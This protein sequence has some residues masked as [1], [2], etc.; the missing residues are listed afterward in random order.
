MPHNT[1]KIMIRIITNLK[2]IVLL[3]I[4]G[5][6]VAQENNTLTLVSPH[7]PPYTYKSNNKIVGLGPDLIRQ[8]LEN[9]NIQYNIVMVKDYGEAVHI[10]KSNLA[11]GMFL[12]SK[13][14]ERDAIAVF[15][16]PLLINKW[17]WFML[18]NSELNP[19][20][21]TFKLQAGIGTIKGTNTYKWLKNN[22]Y[23]IVASPSEA[24]SLV[25]ML[26]S[27]RIDAVFLSDVVFENELDEK[28]LL[29]LNKL[30]EIERDFSMY[31]SHDYLKKHPE[32]I[33][34]INLSIK[35]VIH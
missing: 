18:K 13:N 4:S 21:E 33:D 31:I 2:L 15:T 11:D 6:S 19:K 23:A 17:S 28:T 3:L 32:S 24:S 8:V 25:A 26:K 29:K 30:V 9:A 12:A 1:L 34:K 16:Q 22:G 14:S 20:S 7:F 35:D 10:I 5:T 27:G